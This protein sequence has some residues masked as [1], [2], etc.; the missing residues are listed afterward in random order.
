[1]IF[2][3]KAISGGTHTFHVAKDYGYI[4]ILS[5]L[6]TCATIIV[7]FDLWINWTKFGTFALV[8]N[9]INVVQVIII[10]DV[11]VEF[12]KPLLAQF[13]FIHK[14]I[15]CV[16]DE[17]SNLNTL[18]FSLSIKF[19]MNHYNWRHHLQGFVLFWTYNVQSLSIH[20]N[21]AKA[22]QKTLKDAQQGLQKNYTL[23]TKVQKGSTKRDR[24]CI[25]VSL[26]VWKLKTQVKTRFTSKVFLFYEIL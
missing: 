14:I 18:G 21:D 25:K 24:A 2:K 1:M 23:N 7:T 11:L 8:M 16:K 26:L 20:Q 10:G 13:N 15:A 4:H 12:A 9:F 17:V 6:F 19:L 5:I 3:S 22:L